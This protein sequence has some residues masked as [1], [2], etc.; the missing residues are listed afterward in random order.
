MLNPVEEMIAALPLWLRLLPA[1][2]AGTW[3]SLAMLGEWL[4][5]MR[6]RWR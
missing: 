2:L 6:G 4:D 1:L 3:L 5:T